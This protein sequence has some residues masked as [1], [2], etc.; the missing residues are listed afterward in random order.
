MK[1]LMFATLAGLGFATGVQA[2]DVSARHA[3]VAAAV[4]APAFSWTGFY[5][6]L[7]AGYG[8]GRSTGWFCDAGLFFCD[9]H[10]SRANGF[11][12]GGH[13]GYNFQ[14]NQVVLGLE[15]DLEY[16][17]GR[18]TSVFAAPNNNG[19]YYNRI[20]G[21]LQGSLRGRAGVAVDRALLYVTGGLAFANHGYEV[22]FA[23]NTPFGNWSRTSFGWTVGAGVEYAFAPNWT[24]RLEYRYANFGRTRSFSPAV[25]NNYDVTHKLDTHTVRLGATYLFST[26]P[27][28]VVARY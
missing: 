1:R 3:P 23:P 18:N 14:I 24:A 27:S 5:S 11:V 10:S 20:S 6:G 28:A 19:I 17:F 9:P 4:M 15:A 22:G 12:F 2:A 8:W 25:V 16:N 13:I 26:G 21:G 7:Q